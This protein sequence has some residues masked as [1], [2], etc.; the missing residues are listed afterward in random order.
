[1]EPKIKVN[2]ICSLEKVYI[3]QKS[4]I[5]CLSLSASFETNK[6]GYHEKINIKIPIKEENYKE[7]KKQISESNAEEPILRVKGNLELI[8]DAVCLN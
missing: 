2:G 1:M 4:K 5:Y 6:K 8:L 3:N 7:L